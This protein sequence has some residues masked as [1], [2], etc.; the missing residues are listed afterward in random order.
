MMK[1]VLLTL[2][3]FAVVGCFSLTTAQISTPAPSPSGKISQKVGLTDITVE[4]SRPSVK[5]RTIFGGLVPYGEMWRT[6]ANKNTIVTFSDKVKIAGKELKAGSYALFTV[7]GKDEWEIIFYTDTENWGTPENYDAAKEAVRFKVKPQDFPFPIESFMVHIGNLENDKCTMGLGWDKTWVEFDINLNTD[8]TVSK[9]ISK[10]M[11][12]PDAND[13]Y[14]AGRYYFEAKKD[15]NKAY[16]WI[17]KS[18][19]MDPK[20]WKLRQEALVL[21]AMNKY[22]EAITVAERSKSMAIEANNKDYERM[23][24]ES[25]N[26]WKSKAGKK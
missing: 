1:K 10:V 12:G 22:Q 13:Y 3:A 7:P 23:N 8:E 19:E 9:A 17:H 15:L 20:F 11:S 21:A 4:Y 24:T 5:D 18:N 14:A 25:I 2:A 26:E 6:G 16:E